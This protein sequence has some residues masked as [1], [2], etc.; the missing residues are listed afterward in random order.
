MRKDGLARSN[1]AK[2][3]TCS[4]TRLAPVV[5]LRAPMS[6]AAGAKVSQSADPADARRTRTPH[7]APVANRPAG[8]GASSC[9]DERRH[10][11]GVS[12]GALRAQWDPFRPPPRESDPTMLWST[13]PGRARNEGVI[14]LD[15]AATGS[16]CPYCQRRA[17]IG[18][19]AT[20]DPW[21]VAR[22]YGSPG[23]RKQGPRGA[24]SLPS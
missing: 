10:L 11:G 14:S 23:T 1:A 12:S 4:S 15:S 24:L 5:R 3:R 7:R 8:R 9:P 13:T 17:V 2:R 16:T 21:A 20:R 6:D 18:E 22:S 19:P